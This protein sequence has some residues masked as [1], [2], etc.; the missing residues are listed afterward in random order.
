MN[1][2]LYEESAEPKNIKTQ[3]AF[4]VVYSVFG[5]LT[6]IAAAFFLIFSFADFLSALPRIALF[7]ISSCLNLLLR[8]LYI[9]FGI[10]ENSESRELQAQ[11][12][13]ARF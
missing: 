3:K 6:A 8:G 7:A 12:K 2:V 10:D 9:R 4:Y 11:K 5:W 1:E 13:N